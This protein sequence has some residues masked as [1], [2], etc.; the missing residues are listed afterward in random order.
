MGSLGSLRHRVYMLLCFWGPLIPVCPHTVGPCR[1]NP[2]KVS[3][4]CSHKELTEVP[5]QVWDNATSLDLSHNHLVLNRAAVLGALQ[6]FDQLVYL[7]LS[8]NYLPLLARGY[9]SSLSS[10]RVLDLSSCHLAAVE[11]G[12]LQGMSRLRM[13]FLGNNRLKGQL[14]SLERAGGLTILGLNIQGSP[15]LTSMK[16]AFSSR[17]ANERA[18]V[19]D[20]GRVEQDLALHLYQH[21]KLMTDPILGLNGTAN[22]LNTPSNSW[23]VLVGVLV[24]AI[25]LSVLIALAAKCKL[26]HGYLASYRHSRL[27]EGDTASQGDPSMLDVGFSSR[28]TGGRPLHSATI[29]VDLEDEEEIAGEDDDG[30]IEDNYIQDNER[31]RAAE[32]LE[33]A[34]LEEF[35]N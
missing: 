4:D 14:V 9:F 23:K 6:T 5:E 25:S 35:S 16:R 29:S 32:E 26:L 18:Q 24:T 15:V 31:Q 10:L 33:N 1:V 17:D 27:T 2:D 13:L 30:F 21:R 12:A 20:S 11:T 19:D 22:T 28:G 8:G 34:E 3:F 7:N